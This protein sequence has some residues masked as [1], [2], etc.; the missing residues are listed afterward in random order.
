M[1]EQQQRVLVI[2]L[3]GSAGLDYAATCD[4]IAA[5]YHAGWRVILVHGGSERTNRLGDALGHP[6]RFLTSPSGHTSRYTDLRTRDIFVMAT[7]ALNADLVCALQARGL[8]ALGLSGLDGRLLDGQRKDIIR[9]QDPET[10]RIRIVR[11]DYS[12]RI[13]SV[14]VTLLEMLLAAGMLPVVAPVAIS[15]DNQPLNVDG[16]RAAAAIASSLGAS[17][18]V[19]LSNVVGLMRAYPDVSTLVSQ[20]THNDLD[21]ALSWAQGRM[22]RKVISAGEALRGGVS[23]VMLADGRLTHPVSLALAGQGT[24]FTRETK[25]V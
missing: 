8:N 24:L 18:L 17:Q 3:G 2:K 5:Q 19:I 14:N 1:N 13:T 20:V 7:A 25:Q 22:K 23:R 21:D 15:Q 4:D 11:D 16:D 6:A 10:G 12:G 9:A